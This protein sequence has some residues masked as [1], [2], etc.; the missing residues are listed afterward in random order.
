ML[1]NKIFLLLNRS[2]DFF[3]LPPIQIELVEHMMALKKEND[4]TGGIFYV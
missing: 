1:S 3:A 4:P 2:H